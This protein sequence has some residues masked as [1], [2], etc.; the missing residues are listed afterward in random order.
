MRCRRPLSGRYRLS[1]C[2]VGEDQ[3]QIALKTLGFTNTSTVL[4]G[5]PLPIVTAS[6]GTAY[7]IVGQNRADPAG[8]TA[9]FDLAHRLAIAAR[10]AA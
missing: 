10:K 2:G 1:A 6:Q 4:G 8:L 3:G 9:A 7:D 5:L